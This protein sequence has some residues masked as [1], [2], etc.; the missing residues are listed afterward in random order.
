MSEEERTELEQFK[1]KYP[2]VSSNDYAR[3]D[4][5]E[6]TEYLHF[7]DLLAMEYHI[8]NPDEEE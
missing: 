4:V 5:E 3:M 8:N 7:L 6:R 2:I 1:Q